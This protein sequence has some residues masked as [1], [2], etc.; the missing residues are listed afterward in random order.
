MSSISPRARSAPS[1]LAAALVLLALTAAGCA[2][3][4]ANRRGRDA[5]F[6]Q[7]Y[8][9]AVVEYTKALRLNPDDTGARD[10]LQRA[11]VRASEE[12]LQR[13]RRLA[14]LGKLDEAVV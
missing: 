1:T 9:H 4:S 10:G 12:H 14:G 6:R 8:D 13:A 2:A 5:E 11:K 3:S 7:D